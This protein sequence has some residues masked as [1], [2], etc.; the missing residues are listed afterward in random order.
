MTALAAA[1]EARDRREAARARARAL[2]PLTDAQVA[3]IATLLTM[4]STQEPKR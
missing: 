4:G 1:L 3:R 2:P